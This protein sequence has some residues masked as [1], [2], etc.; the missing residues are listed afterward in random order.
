[1]HFKTP[2]ARFTNMGCQWHAQRHTHTH[3]RIFGKC[4]IECHEL[5]ERGHRKKPSSTKWTRK[6]NRITCHSFRSFVAFAGVRVYVCVLCIWYP[7]DDFILFYFFAIAFNLSIE[8]CCVACVGTASQC[9][10]DSVLRTT[11]YAIH[12]ARSHRDPIGWVNTSSRPN[13]RQDFL[14]L[15]FVRCRHPSHPAMAERKRNT[16]PDFVFSVRNG[17]QMAKRQPN[18]VNACCVRKRLKSSPRVN[19]TMFGDRLRFSWMPYDQRRTDEKK[20]IFRSLEM[21]TKHW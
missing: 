11:S 14:L 20:N 5:I 3:N 4:S 7:T 9:H 15:L 10:F 1:M 6:V 13:K 8:L 21:T 2:C 12:S 19:W 16:M 18:P 17:K